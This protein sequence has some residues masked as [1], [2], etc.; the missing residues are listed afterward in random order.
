MSINIK[1][2]LRGGALVCCCFVCSSGTDVSL[3]NVN[4]PTLK[5]NRLEYFF[6]CELWRFHLTKRTRLQIVPLLKSA[7][8]TIEKRQADDLTA[9]SS[10][11]DY[12]NKSVC[13]P[14]ERVFSFLAFVF[15]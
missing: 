11:E 15:Y 3:Q 4:L 9:R 14:T 12:E 1:V 6:A 13:S 7:I 8:R 10:A 5:R 2:E